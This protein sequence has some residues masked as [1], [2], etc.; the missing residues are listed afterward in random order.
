MYMTTARAIQISVTH[1]SFGMLTGA[2]IEA[3]MPA[4][5]ASSSS[6]GLAF[7]A[8]VQV[9]MNG[10]LLSQIGP[11]LAGADDPTFGLPFSWGLLLAQPGRKSRVEVLALLA[12]QRVNQFALKMAPLAQEEESATPS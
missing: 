12:R 5:S 8:F 1:L 3:F 9:A 7:E 10:V 4:H 11:Q 2:A 6:A